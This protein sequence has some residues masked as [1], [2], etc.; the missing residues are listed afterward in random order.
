MSR[1]PTEQPSQRAQTSGGASR[2]QTEQPSQQAHTSGSGSNQSHDVLDRLND[3]QREF[4]DYQVAQ[5]EAMANMQRIALEQEQVMFRGVN[6]LEIGGR[7]VTK[8][9]LNVSFIYCQVLLNKIRNFRNLIKSLFLNYEVSRE[10]FTETERS[11]RVLQESNHTS[12]PPLS[13]TR[14]RLLHEAVKTRNRL[15]P[16]TMAKTWGLITRAINS[17]GRSLKSKLLNGHLFPTRRRHN[18]DNNNNDENE[19]NNNLNTSI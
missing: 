17:S 8:F 19:N 3:L 2:W 9:A 18:V 16:K 4:R 12:R 1:W 5:R 10:L 15:S 11:Q 13:P 7:G 14:V 6:L